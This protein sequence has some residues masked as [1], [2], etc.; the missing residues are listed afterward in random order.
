M[1]NTPDSSTIIPAPPVDGSGNRAEPLIEDT[2]QLPGSLLLRSR[3]YLRH[4]YDRQVLAARE[5]GRLLDV[6]R[7]GI[8]GTLRL[9]RV[10]YLASRYDG[11]GEPQHDYRTHEALRNQAV[12]EEDR[13]PK[14]SSLLAALLV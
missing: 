9:S 14:L 5:I 7:T 8:G 11:A 2:V 10:E 1:P 6:N 12:T 4:L 3:N 13:N